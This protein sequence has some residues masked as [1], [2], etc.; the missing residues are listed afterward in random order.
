MDQIILMSLLNIS[1]MLLTLYF[2]KKLIQST[3]PYR[4]F[5]GLLIVGL[6][7]SSFMLGTF[8]L[9]FGFIPVFINSIL[10]AVFLRGRK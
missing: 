6:T 5:V 4:N 10:V 8:G 7:A 1:L 3:C 9:I 2:G